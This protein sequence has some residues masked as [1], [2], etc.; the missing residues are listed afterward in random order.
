MFGIDL[1]TSCIRLAQYERAGIS[2][3]DITRPDGEGGDEEDDAIVKVRG[4]AVFIG[5]NIRCPVFSADNTLECGAL[6]LIG[7]RY[8]DSVRAASEHWPFP[9]INVNGKPHIRCMV[10]GQP[11]DVK[12]QTVLTGIFRQVKRAA[13][14]IR[15]QRPQFVIAIPGTYTYAHKREILSAANDANMTVECLVSHTTA[16]AV[17]RV[18]EHS[19]LSELSETCIFIDL[20]AGS[21]TISAIRTEKGHIKILSTV[22][23]SHWGGSDITKSLISYCCEFYKR[24]TNRD[25]SE[26]NVQ[27][28]VTECE[29]AKLTLNATRDSSVDITLPPPLKTCRLTW[30]TIT[31]R[32]SDRLRNVS[33][34]LTRCMEEANIDPNKGPELRVVLIGGSTRLRG[35]EDIV[36]KVITRNHSIED[37]SDKRNIVAFGAAI[38]C[39]YLVNAF[40][41]LRFAGVVIEEIIPTLAVR[42][43]N[44]EM[45]AMIASRSVPILSENALSATRIFNIGGSEACDV[46]VKVYELERSY[47]NR[48]VNVGMTLLSVPECHNDR[49]IIVSFQINKNTF[50]VNAIEIESNESNE[51]DILESEGLSEES[52]A[53]DVQELIPINAE[54]CI[55]SIPRRTVQ[56]YKVPETRSAD[57]SPEPPQAV[58]RHVPKKSSKNR[59]SHSSA[60]GGKFTEFG[61]S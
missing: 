52:Q 18:S 54:L 59:A 36:Y 46:Y 41:R 53:S 6:C 34:L 39:N 2:S 20:G 30:S 19:S 5:D 7:R 26:K 12:P 14:K 61:T 17:N 42:S 57:S 44:G 50:T 43:R 48:Y 9:V 11:V 38:I 40:S 51:S 29:R 49:A 15:K 10:N 37:L 55:Q 13:A 45:S 1:G 25:L 23:E 3:V 58:P 4:D 32:N 22:G 47:A 60:M 28:L 27:M 31:E 24:T 16:G 33:N 35:I 21:L 8:N 56:G